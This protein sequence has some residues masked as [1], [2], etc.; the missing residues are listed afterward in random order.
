MKNFLVF[1]IFISAPLQVFSQGRDT[2]FAVHKLFRE[3]RAT[4]QHLESYRDSSASKAYYAERADSPLTKQE[5]NQN[6]LGNTAFTLVGAM[7]TSRYSV[8][9]ETDIIRRYNNGGPIPAQVRR[10]L[11]RKHFHRTTRDVLE[12]KN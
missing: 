10:K 1:F 3:K 2:V 6:A 9:E 5:I 7:K 11:K 8:E 4:G 12:A